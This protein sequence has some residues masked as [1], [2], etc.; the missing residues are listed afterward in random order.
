MRRKIPVAAMQG[1]AF[2]LVIDL[3]PPYYEGIGKVASAH[4]ILENRV[5]E[6]LFD[7]MAVDYPIGR[8]AFEYRHPAVLFGLVR[9]LLDLRGIQIKQ[10]LLDVEH[11]AKEQ[12]LQEVEDEIRSHSRERDKLAHGVWLV[13]PNAQLALRVTEGQFTTEAG[14]HDRA[15]LPEPHLVPVPWFDW[16]RLLT[17]KT[18]KK[19][20]DVRAEVKPQIAALLEK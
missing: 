17:L 18:A 10:T 6:L 19:I 1:G 11:D 12:N 16:Q 14:I 5:Q 3:P 7:L 20:S 13:M 9:R 2:P 8:V 15:F 4:A